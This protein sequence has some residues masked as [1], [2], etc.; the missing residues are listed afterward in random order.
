MSAGGGVPTTSKILRPWAMRRKNILARQQTFCIFSRVIAQ[1]GIIQFIS[2]ISSGSDYGSFAQLYFPEIVYEN[3]ISQLLLALGGIYE[4]HLDLRKKW[5]VDVD[6][7]AYLLGN[8]DEVST[9]S[10]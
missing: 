5:K 4:F 7:G 1:I 8:N 2:I 9:S 3:V 10:R 6:M